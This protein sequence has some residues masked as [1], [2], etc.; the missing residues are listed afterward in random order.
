[1]DH[2]Q[3]DLSRLSDENGV[4]KDKLKVTI[5]QNGDQDDVARD[6]VQQLQD[7]LKVCRLCT[8]I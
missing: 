7:A 5:S 2:F 6:E 4:L 3:D 8:I 1:M